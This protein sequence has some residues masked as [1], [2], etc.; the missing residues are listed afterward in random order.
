M[1]GS[2]LRQMKIVQLITGSASFGGAEAHVRDLSVG[3]RA[4]GHECTVMVG[5]PEGLLSQQL[6]SSGV[7]VVMVPALLKPLHPVRDAASLL[8]VIAELE[9]SAEILAT[10][11][12][13]AGY[14]GRI[15]AK[16]LGVP[17]FFTPHGLSFID[18]QTGDPIKFRLF[19]NS[20]R[21]SWAAR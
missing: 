12:A 7:P 15:A 13:K 6:R 14:V 1:V 4:R 11:T 20:S 18:R 9:S 19:S 3:L 8:R 10:H 16:W 2:H 17:S 5:P 21:S